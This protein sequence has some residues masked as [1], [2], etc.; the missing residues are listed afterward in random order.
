[1]ID[2]LYHIDWV[3]KK[4]IDQDRISSLLSPCISTGRFTN[5]GPNVE[6]LEIIIK[7][8]LKVDDSKAIIIVSNGSVALHILTSAI[9][10]YHKTISQWATQSFTFPA[11]AQGTLSNAKIVD[12]DLDG[13]LDISCIDESVNGLIV[14]NIFGNV[15]DIDK[16]IDYC[17]KNN[18][19]LIFDN[20]ATAFTFYKGKNCVNYGDGCI[21]SL[22]HTKPFGFGEGG[23]IIVDNK[24]E[25]I[26]R[27]F[28]NFG[29]N[30]TDNYYISQGNNS[31]MS[32]ISAIYIIQYIENNFDSI[33]TNH[34]N[35]YYYLKGL[36]ETKYLYLNCKLFPSF[37]NDIIT[38]ACFPLLF[39][40]Y[41]DNIRI[42]LLKKGIFCRKY[43]HPLE[44]TINSTN[45]YNK[46][47][48]IP[49]TKDM[50]INDIDNI[51]NI[52][53]IGYLN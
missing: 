48:C 6:L 37:H 23:A 32:D 16:Y 49:C 15:V 40:N 45:I 38:P 10:Y 47:L 41:N 35:I 46:I 7:E 19:F 17:N 28:I 2:T 26:I 22:H 43:Y 11:S 8:K 44:N 42:T 25:K 27:S 39:D 24:Y 53:S 9:D 4:N 21:I 36:L 20:A 51:L 29:N 52:I 33:I 30:L 12:I 31:K 1:M 3:P 50:N 13:G 18:K 34:Q 14:T 5:Y